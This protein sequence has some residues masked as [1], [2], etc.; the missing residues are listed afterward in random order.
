VALVD[1][2][3]EIERELPADW[4]DARLRLTIPDEGNCDRA[5]ALLAPANPG[6]RGKVIR[7]YAARRG[8]GAGPERIRSLLRRLDTE[9][10]QGE[11]EL[12]GSG[13]AEATPAP[14]RTPSLAESWQTALRSLPS[15]WSDVYA[16]VELLSSDY[17]ERAALDL[18][19]ANPA[20]FGGRPALRFRCARVRGYGVSPEMALRCFERCDEDG[21]RGRVRILRALSDTGPVQT[22]GPVWYVG[23]RSV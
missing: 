11:L 12:L 17:L 19:P 8:L 5:A 10:I 4:S 6:R 1:Q 9:R 13:T 14:A 7:L 16:E 2:W 20:R 15:D 3:H 23:G 21:I 18:S 22:Q